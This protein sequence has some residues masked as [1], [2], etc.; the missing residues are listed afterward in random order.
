MNE[1]R[2]AFLRAIVVNVRDYVEQ[3]P[4]VT[5][6][7]VLKMLELALTTAVR[8]VAEAACKWCGGD[9]FRDTQRDQYRHLDRVFSVG[10]RAASAERGLNNEFPHSW[11]A[12]PPRKK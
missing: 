7:D 2:V 5:G 8:P 4:D 10:C 11:K 12:C 9:I 3:F 1:D 6:A